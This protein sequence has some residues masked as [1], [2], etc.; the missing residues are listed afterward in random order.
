MVA[1]LFDILRERLGAGE[2][3]KLARFGTFRLREKP[4][5]VGRNP[6]TGEAVSIGAPRIVSFHPSAV[7]RER[8]DREDGRIS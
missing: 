6:R 7:L 4:A 1:A 8:L 2:E 5:R 3:V